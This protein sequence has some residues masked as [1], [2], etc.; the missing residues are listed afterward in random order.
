MPDPKV[1]G[2]P[3]EN[4]VIR[5]FLDEEAETEDDGLFEHYT[6]VIAKGQNPL[7]ID[8]FLTNV[9][10]MTSRSKIQNASVT[11]S[12]TVNEKEVKMSYKVK[13]GDT[14]RLMLPYPPPPELKPENIPLDIRWEDPDLILL[15]KSPGMVCHPS[16]GHWGA[17]LVH[18]LLWHFEHLPAPLRTQELPRPGLVHRIDK[19]T[20]GLMVVAKTEYAMAHLSRQFFDHSTER[21]YQALVWGNISQDKGTVVAS[22]GRHPKERK[23]YAVVE[24]GKHAVTH[25]RVLERFG[26]ATLVECK[27]ETGRTHQI[28]VHMKHIGHPLISDTFYGGDTVRGGPFDKRT[29]DFLHHIL[30]VIPRQALHAKTLGLTHP[31]TGERLQ[32]DSELP[33]DFAQALAELR[34]WNAAGANPL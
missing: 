25:Y 29:L 27:L 17:T 32:F 33:D 9:M 15:H 13:P 1:Y 31:H 11:G 24:S 28:R 21:T 7:R 16:L 5:H 18:A 14:I 10:S 26:F 12:I 19:D 3:S 6:F 8:K 34:Q 2:R 22:I 30:K 4:Q 23:L 20:S